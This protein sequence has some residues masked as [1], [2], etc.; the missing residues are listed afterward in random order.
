[1][2]QFWKYWQV[3]WYDRIVYRQVNPSP[4]KATTKAASCQC[5]NGSWEEED[6]ADVAKSGWE[7]AVGT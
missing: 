2:S 3:C 6:T 1:M 5:R 7:D 4:T